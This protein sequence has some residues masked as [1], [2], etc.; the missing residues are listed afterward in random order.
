MPANLQASSS[1]PRPSSGHLHRQHRGPLGCFHRPGWHSGR[2]HR[3]G[4]PRPQERPLKAV[5]APSPAWH[6]VVLTEARPGA[7][8][9]QP[10]PFPLR[11]G[12]VPLVHGPQIPDITPGARRE[13]H[14]GAFLCMSSGL[15]PSYVQ[16]F[17]EQ[18]NQ[19]AKKIKNPAE[20]LKTTANK[21]PEIKQKH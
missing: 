10:R 15:N 17:I 21:H 12:P 3:Q 20:L 2:Q 9:P 14:P 19:Q 6:P 7:A 16:I 13:F 8:L 4:L 18:K 1:P 5:T 11:P